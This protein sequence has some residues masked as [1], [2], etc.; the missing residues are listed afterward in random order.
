M[1]TDRPGAAGSVLSRALATLRHRAFE[2]QP[3]PRS[4]QRNLALVVL[5]TVAL[6]YQVLIVPAVAPA[7]MRQY[8]MSFPQ[9]ADVLAVALAAGAFGS[10][11]TGRS[12]E[13]GR[14]G[15]LIAALGGASLLSLLALPAM[16]G[17]L[18]FGAAFA[19]VGL[20]QGVALAGT[21]ALVRD[22][23]PGLG[24][25]TAM[26]LWAAGPVLAS[27]LVAEVASH[28]LPA[29]SGFRT[30]FVIAGGFGL[31][32]FAAALLFLRDLAPRL[33]EHPLPGGYRRYA[34]DAR[35]RPDR[36]HPWLQMLRGEV[37]G[38]S[39]AIS[40][41]LLLYLTLVGFG[42]VY[43]TTNYGFSLA[44]ANA[45]GDW[46]WAFDAGTVLL[47]GVLS[48]RLGVRKPLILLGAVGSILLTVLVVLTT[49]HPAS[50]WPLLVGIMCLAA[51]LMAVVF[52]QWLAGFTEM[53]ERLNPA[54]TGR[55]FA[56]WGWVLQAVAASAFFVLP[57]VVH[58]VTPL[59]RHEAQVNHLEVA[60]DGQ[61]S[62]IGEARRLFTR[63]RSYP[64]G[65]APASLRHALA[66]RVGSRALR[67]VEQA[68][69]RLETL[70]RFRPAVN[71]AED[72]APYRWMLWWWIC[73]ICALPM[74]AVALAMRGRWIPEG[75][76][77]WLERRRG[78]DRRAAGGVDAGSPG[79]RS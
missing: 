36:H 3:D 10:L 56:I 12:D 27:M 25:G 76:R 32:V 70:Y 33:R 54:L 48:D 17:V 55:G 39:V 64:P 23:T 14:A 59:V 42:V 50:G 38:S 20:A 75:L 63:L 67:Q 62:T 13:R 22:F 77:R 52:G 7:L 5:T 79:V 68:R 51:M 15:T 4:R 8:G 9:F 73:A 78:R 60:L 41:Y 45:P 11:L 29:V 66:A 16:P 44:A 28:T 34:V 1:T 35:G 58:P 26:G 6:F 18:S 69:P 61:L 31:A 37:V 72:R 74:L 71:R 47:L 40:L 57:M 2:E 30:Q 53:L 19:A 43:L 24:R 49:D 46:A 21:P 65:G